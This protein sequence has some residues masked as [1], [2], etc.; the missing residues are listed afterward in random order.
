MIL[1]PKQMPNLGK[2]GRDYTADCAPLRP[3]L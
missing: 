1:P 2:V 3:G